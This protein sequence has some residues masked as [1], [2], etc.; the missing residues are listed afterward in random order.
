MD[1]LGYFYTHFHNYHI[2]LFLPGSPGFGIDRIE[3][4]GILSYY[5]D[6]GNYHE[7]KV[8]SEVGSIIL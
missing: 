3:D 1:I 8:V 2:S 4:Y 7:E 6:G 5:D